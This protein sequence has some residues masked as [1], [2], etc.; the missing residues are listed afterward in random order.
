MIFNDHKL[1]DFELRL[2][3]RLRTKGNSGIHIRGRLGESKSHAVKGYHA[4]FGHVGIGPRVLGAWDFH[5]APRGDYMVARGQKV[6]IDK[7]GKKHFSK[8]KDAFKPTD[9]KKGGWN[10]VVVVVK[11][12]KMHFTINGKMCSAIIDDEVGQ[13]IPYGL[14]GLQVHGGPPMRIEFKN[15]FLKRLK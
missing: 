15:V 14:I 5:G 2:S 13:R 3:Y 10:D 11:G 4:D 9:I 12:F 1:R 7:N 6:H 8:I